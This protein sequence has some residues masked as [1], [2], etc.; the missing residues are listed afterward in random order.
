MMLWG[1]FPTRRPPQ[2]MSWFEVYS[3]IIGICRRTKPASDTEDTVPVSVTALPLCRPSQDGDNL[4]QTPQGGVNSEGLSGQ[5]AG[6]AN[7]CN[8]TQSGLSLSKP[9]TYRISLAGWKGKEVRR[10]KKIQ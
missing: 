5:S 10:G 4:S 1:Y 2:S 3:L 7:I 8:P 6:L 9:K